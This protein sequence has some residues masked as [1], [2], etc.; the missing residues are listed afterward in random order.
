[1]RHCPTSSR[2]VPPATRP[3]TPATQLLPFVPQAIEDGIVTLPGPRYC[4]VLETGAVNLALLH[5]DELA[6]LAGTY[7]GLLASLSFPVQ[8]LARVQPADPVPYLHWY[9][10]QTAE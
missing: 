6:G 7:H 4:A 3:S 10:A 8:L 1:M 9:E 2:S 5:P